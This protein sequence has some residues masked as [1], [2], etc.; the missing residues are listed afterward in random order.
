MGEGDRADQ[1]QG[2]TALIMPLAPGALVPTTFE[3][4]LATYGQAYIEWYL[5]YHMKRTLLIYIYTG[6]SAKELITYIRS[7]TM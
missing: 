7:R 5:S 2:A 6:N 1:S 4:Q 3:T